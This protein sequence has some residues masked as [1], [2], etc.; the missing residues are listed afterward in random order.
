MPQIPKKTSSENRCSQSPHLV[1]AK[2]VSETADLVGV[3]R[4]T[5]YRWMDDPAFREEYDRQ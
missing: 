1:S 5:V 3:T 2:S 4:R